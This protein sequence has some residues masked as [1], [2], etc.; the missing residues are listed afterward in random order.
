MGKMGT[1]NSNIAVFRC[2]IQSRVTVRTDILR[3]QIVSVLG[4]N[5]RKIRFMNAFPLLS[6]H[7]RQNPALLLQARETLLKWKK[8]GLVSQTRF[9]QWRIILDDAIQDNAGMKRLLDLLL[10]ES[11]QAR[12]IKDFAPFAGLLPREERRKVFMSCAYDH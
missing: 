9:E 10:D 2:L 3:K 12:Q 7:V 8:N 11:D 4:F 6:E 5:Y 1:K